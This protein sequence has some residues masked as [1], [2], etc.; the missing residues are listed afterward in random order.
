MT[1]RFAPEKAPTGAT[2]AKPRPTSV[3]GPFG[4]TLTLDSLPPPDTNRWV[5][6]RK[7]EV[8][9]AINGGL[10]TLEEACVRYRLSVEELRLWQEAVE[11]AGVPGLRVT[12][13]QLY[14]DVTPAPFRRNPGA[15]SPASGHA[16]GS[17]SHA[18]GLSAWR[19]A[20]PAQ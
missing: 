13:I 16:E 9:A 17:L 6:R 19:M 3:T 18:Q 4:A 11:R 5:A 20:G 12:R 8:L 2:A 10:L 7:A 15:G 1:T 14:R